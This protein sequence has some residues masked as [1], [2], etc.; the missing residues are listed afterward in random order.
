MGYEMLRKGKPKGA[1]DILIHSGISDADEYL[2]QI[3]ADLSTQ[4]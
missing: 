2:G 3:V 4:K 1:R